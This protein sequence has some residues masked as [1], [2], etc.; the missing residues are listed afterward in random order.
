MQ[1]PPESVADDHADQSGCADNVHQVDIHA[2]FFGKDFV[3]TRQTE[4]QID[5]REVKT[6]PPDAR[7]AIHQQGG[8][9]RRLLRR[10]L[11]TGRL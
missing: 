1:R 5:Q 4:E 6:Q 11:E 2:R 9:K 8:L 10:G 3:E 7:I